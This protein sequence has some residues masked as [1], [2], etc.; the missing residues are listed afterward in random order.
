MPLCRAPTKEFMAPMRVQCWRSKLAMNR[1]AQS[2]PA[3]SCGSVPLPARTPG[4]VKPRG[5]DAAI[6]GTPG[7]LAGED[8]CATSLLGSWLQLTSKSWRC[9]MNRG[10]RHKTLIQVDQSY[11]RRGSLVAMPDPGIKPPMNPPG[12][13]ASLPARCQTR[14]APAEM[15]A[16]PCES[17]PPPS[18]PGPARELPVN[19]PAIIAWG[20]RTI[21]PLAARESAG[22]RKRGSFPLRSLSAWVAPA[23]P[24]ENRN[25]VAQIRS[26]YLINPCL[27]QETMFPTR[28]T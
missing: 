27:S 7:E 20:P 1:V 14:I 21:L 15:P 3:A 10:R 2:V 4:G 11:V 28:R 17:E 9:S 23:R 19:P 26:P 18:T 16:L 25:C 13:P 5:G 8:A 6:R 12:A 22:A 24:A